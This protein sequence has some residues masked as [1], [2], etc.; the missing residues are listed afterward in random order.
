MVSFDPG[1]ENGAK[2]PMRNQERRIGLSG[3]RRIDKN[4]GGSF[5]CIVCQDRSSVTF[6]I[7]LGILSRQ[8]THLPTQPLLFPVNHSR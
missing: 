2:F 5:P 3:E 6:A 8:F 7:S 4:S 1:K